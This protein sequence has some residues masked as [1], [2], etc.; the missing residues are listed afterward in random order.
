VSGFL[1]YFVDILRPNAATLNLQ[2]LPTFDEIYRDYSKLVYNLTLSYVQNV[3]DAQDITQDVFIKIYKQLDRYDPASASLKTWIYRIS[4]NTC[5]DFIKMKQSSKRFGFLTSLFRKDSGEPVI[6]PADFNHPG[7][8]AE[9]KDELRRL[10]H[11]INRLPENQKT[12]LILSKIESHSQR[13]IAQIM[14]ISEKA[15]ESLL[16]RAK[17]NLEK[18]SV[19]RRKN[20]H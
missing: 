12:A 19:E 10:F 5:L 14:N 17:Q 13:E 1:P 2:S 20:N 18:H 15:V 4:V 11:L 9:H 16:Q 6:S 8:A 3:E 7:I